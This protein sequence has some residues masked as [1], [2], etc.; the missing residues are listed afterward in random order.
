[1]SGFDRIITSL[2]R[3]FQSMWEMCR[4]AIDTCG[5][6]QWRREIDDPFFVPGRVILHVIE[7]A[8]YYLDAHPDSFVWGA[9]ADFETCP[10]ADLPGEA[11]VAVRRSQSSAAAAS[12]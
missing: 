4:E 6:S 2:A 1:M 10:S 5:E 9:L 8:D 3:Q 11:L 7:T 12:Q